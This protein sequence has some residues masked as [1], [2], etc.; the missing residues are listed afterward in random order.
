MCSPDLPYYTALPTAVAANQKHYA[1]FYLDFAMPRA[2]NPIDT[3]LR[4]RPDETLDCVVTWGAPSDI[5][6]ANPGNAT[7]NSG[8]VSIHSLEEV[9]GLI[10][11]LWVNK[12]YTIE[13]EVTA[14]TPNF[15]IPLNGANLYRGF[16]INADV[17]GNPNGSVISSIELK[18]GVRTFRKWDWAELQAYNKSVF[19]IEAI[20]TGWVFIDMAPDG[21]LTQSLDSKGMTDLELSFNVTKQAGTNKIRV[22]P[23]ELVVP[24]AA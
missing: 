7:I 9:T 19:D 13:K 10:N 18:N 20:P 21:M 14:T 11:P 16:L 22:Y 8:S 15:S 12:T 6:S 5:Y 23:I 4:V 17:D 1:A 24:T 3:L 2:I